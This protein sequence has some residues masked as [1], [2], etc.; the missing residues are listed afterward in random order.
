MTEYYS[1]KDLTPQPPLLLRGGFLTPKAPLSTGEGSGVRSF[2]VA[3]IS[4]AT[5]IKLILPKSLLKPQVL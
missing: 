3:R 5:T 2:A 1:A 4:Q